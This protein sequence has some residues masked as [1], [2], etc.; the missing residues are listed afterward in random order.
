MA[1]AFSCGLAQASPLTGLPV[2][3]GLDEAY[4]IK[5]NTSPQAIERGVKAAMD[6]IN[7]KGGVLGGRPLKLVTTDNQGVAARGK[8]IDATIAAFRDSFAAVA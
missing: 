2:M 6:E 4:S 7:A 1:G 8:D 5:S 3:V